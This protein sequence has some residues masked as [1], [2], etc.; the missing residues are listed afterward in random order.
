ML[1]K[2]VLTFELVM[3][4]WSVA[5]QMKATRQCRTYFL[6]FL[7]WKTLMWQTET[8]KQRLILL[9][10]NDCKAVEIVLSS[11]TFT[12][13]YYLVFHNNVVQI[14]TEQLYIDLPRWNLWLFWST[15]FPVQQ[16]QGTFGSTRHASVFPQLS[17]SQSNGNWIKKKYK[18]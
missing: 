6:Q 15:A 2:V 1:F 4:S 12:F 11:L 17:F 5:I 18:Y 8:L 13:Y 9:M 3:I 16:C 14:T 10:D 7:G